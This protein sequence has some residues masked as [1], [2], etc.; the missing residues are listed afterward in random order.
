MT[1]AGNRVTID[2]GTD[3]SDGMPYWVTL[4]KGSILDPSANAYAG[5][6]KS[7]LTFTTFV[8]SRRPWLWQVRPTMAPG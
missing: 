2:P 8:R 6:K 3:L 7:L 4:P 5:L 1:F